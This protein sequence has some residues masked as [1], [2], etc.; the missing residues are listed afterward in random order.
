MIFNCAT[1]FFKICFLKDGD[2]NSLQVLSSCQV[3]DCADAAKEEGGAGGPADKGGLTE[4]GVL[5]KER[6]LVDSDMHEDRHK[7]GTE[8]FIGIC[9]K[10]PENGGIYGL[11]EVAVVDAKKNGGAND[12]SLYV[13]ELAHVT[14][15]HA[16]EQKLLRKGG[17]NAVGQD[18]RPEGCAGLK[19]RHLLKALRAAGNAA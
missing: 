9:D 11:S 1:F 5:H 17:A 7:E 12:G 8:I 3:D 10:V 14:V 16:A 19:L 4:A 13:K 18:G 15:H 6:E 2:F